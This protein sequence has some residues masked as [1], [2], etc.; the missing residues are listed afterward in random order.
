MWKEKAV[1][2]W[3]CCRNFF[4]ES[5]SY[6]TLKQWRYS[7]SGLVCRTWTFRFYGVYCGLLLKNKL[8]N[9]SSL[10]E[11]KAVFAYQLTTYWLPPEEI[12]ATLQVD[13]TFQ[14]EF[15]R[16]KGLTLK[17]IA[18]TERQLFW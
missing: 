12:L 13:W 15:A 6:V 18:V 2:S 11:R 16:G 3:R 7:V 5:M 14:V 4:Q 9:I 8:K 17:F 10:L 1:G